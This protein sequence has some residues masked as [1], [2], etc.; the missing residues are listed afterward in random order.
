MPS[1]E[2]GP[3][4]RCVVAIAGRTRAGKTTLAAA[5]AG[6]LGWPSASFSSY[7]RAEAGR[8]GI[9]ERRRSLQDLGASMIETM[10]PRAFVEGMFENAG[11]TVVEHAPLLIEGIRHLTVLEAL[12]D[13]S[14]P[15]P[16]QLIYLRVSD[17]ERNRRLAGEG[18]SAREGEEWEEHS[19]EQDVLHGLEGQ[20]DLVI[21]AD[22]PRDF[23]ANTALSRLVKL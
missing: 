23:V 8:R 9:E 3:P 11:L 1:P 18:I 10:G 15:V 17:A 14:A 19:T 2:Q 6:E 20:A 5:L 7:V 13:V 4:S 12:R 16:T 22:K 21:A